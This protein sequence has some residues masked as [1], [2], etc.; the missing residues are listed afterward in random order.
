MRKAS[1]DLNDDVSDGD[2]YQ[3]GGKDIAHFFN[4]YYPMLALA[5]YIDDYNN[6]IV[7]P[8]HDD[9]SVTSR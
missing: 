2:E 9:Y 6:G 3:L 7:G 5:S 8:G 1:V 4:A